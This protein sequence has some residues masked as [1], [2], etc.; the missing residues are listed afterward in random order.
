MG[1]YVSDEQSFETVANVELRDGLSLDTFNAAVR[2]ITRWEGGYG[3]VEDLVKDLHPIMTTC[4]AA[5]QDVP[6]GD[7]PRL[8]E[9]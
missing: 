3:E 8:D 2:A 1:G 5:L 9:T 7:Y 4:P 6:R